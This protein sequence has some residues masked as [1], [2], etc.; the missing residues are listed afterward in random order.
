MRGH[1]C[2]YVKSLGGHRVLVVTDPGLASAGVITP[3]RRSLE[4]AGIGVEVFS[5]V[6]ADPPESVVAGAVQAATA[7]AAE[8]IVGLG[9]GSSMDTAKLAALL[10]RTP[11]PLDNVYGIDRARGPTAAH[12]GAHHGRHRFRK[13]LPSPSSRRPP[14]RR[15]A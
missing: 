11:Q 7:C 6:R 14:T 2:Q 3:A 8:V 9:G 12:P 10:A 15:R 4:G 13:S 5:D 1:P